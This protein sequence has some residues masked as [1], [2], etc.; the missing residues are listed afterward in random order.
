MLTHFKFIQRLRT[1]EWCIDALAGALLLLRAPG[2]F[3][4][5]LSGNGVSKAWQ[6]LAWW[7]NIVFF[8]PFSDPC[9]QHLLF[10]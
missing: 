10:D 2:S 7:I 1:P 3:F 9:C 6:W 8:K 5:S 4:I